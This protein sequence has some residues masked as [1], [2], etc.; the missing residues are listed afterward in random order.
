MNWGFLCGYGLDQGLVFGSY[1]LCA[2]LDARAVRQFQPLEVRIE[3]GLSGA[4]GVRAPDRGK[5]SFA[6][7]AASSHEMNSL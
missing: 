6:A 3:P 1:A 7:D 5:I 4:H 2:G